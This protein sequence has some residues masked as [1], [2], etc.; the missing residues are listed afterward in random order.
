L[1]KPFGERGPEELERVQLAVR[2]LAKRLESRLVKKDRR[3]RKGSLNVRKTLRRNMAL[4]GSLVDLAFRQR[5]RQRPEVMVLCDVSDSVRNVSRMM[6]LFVHTLQAQFAGVRSFAFVSD[7]GEIT[8][9]FRE[10]DANQALD[11]ALAGKAI[12]RYGNSNYGRMLTQF[13]GRYLPSVTRRTTVL[14]IGDA[15]NNYNDPAVWALQAIAKKARRVV[16]ITPE[17]EEAWGAGDSE[18]LC[19]RDAVSRVVVV[20]KLAD[21]EGLADKLV[22]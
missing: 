6:L 22:A 21:L 16:W 10:A 13:V 9:A 1:E 17:P 20:E 8:E 15:R 19:Y 14:V 2:R 12:D 5:K 3:R 11:V 18:M 4:D 7:V